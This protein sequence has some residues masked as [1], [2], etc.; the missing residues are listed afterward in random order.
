MSSLYPVAS[1]TLPQA[2]DINQFIN[3]LN[4]T[5]DVG[6]ITLAPLLANPT[7]T[8]FSLLAQAGSS[9]GVGAYNYQFTYVTGQYKTDNTLLVTGE[10]LPTSALPITTTSGNTTVKVTVPTLLPSSVIAIRIYRTSVGGS[11]YKLITTLKAGNTQYIDS[12]ADGSRGVVPP[13]ANT[14]GTMLNAQNPFMYVRGGVW[15]GIGSSNTL[16]QFPTTTGN[17]V[18]TT[19]LINGFHFSGYDI[20]CDIAGTYVL[21]MLASINGLTTGISWESVIRRYPLG[22]GSFGDDVFGTYGYNAASTTY[23][24]PDGPILFHEIA[25]QLSVSDK[26]Q[27]FTRAGEAPRNINAFMLKIERISN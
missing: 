15:G 14:T 16:A 27:F 20:I 18:V 19:S 7:T 24:S 6:P 26:I 8:G 3:M 9:L 12:T 13:T 1:G 23:S 21:S 4:G 25:L 2:T 10:T 22:G 5:N 17:G 11:D